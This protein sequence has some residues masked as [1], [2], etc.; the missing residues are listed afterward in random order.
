M[1]KLNERLFTIAVYVLIV[2]LFTVL[3]GMIFFN[4]GTIFGFIKDV[5]VKLSSVF[6][7]II[8]ALILLPVVRKLEYFFSKIFKKTFG[9]SPR[10]YKQTYNTFYQNNQKMA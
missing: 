2:I 6:Y 9:L 3:F 1:K 4:I 5:T 10:D 7:A 8:I